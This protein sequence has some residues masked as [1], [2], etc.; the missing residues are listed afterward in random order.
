LATAEIRVCRAADLTG[1][2]MWKCPQAA[3]IL[4]LQI[5]EPAAGG[6]NG[7]LGGRES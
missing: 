6:G 4:K 3:R 1:P 2:R 7:I 5:L